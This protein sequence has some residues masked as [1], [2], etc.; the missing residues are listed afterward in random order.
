[1]RLVIWR[2][3]LLDENFL[4]SPATTRFSMPGKPT[5]RSRLSYDLRS[6][7]TLADK[8]ALGIFSRCSNHEANPLVLSVPPIKAYTSRWGMRIVKT[9]GT[10]CVQHQGKRS[11][12]LYRLKFLRLRLRDWVFLTVVSKTRSVNAPGWR[13]SEFK[14]VLSW[15]QAGWRPGRIGRLQWYPFIGIRRFTLHTNR[16]FRGSL[17]RCLISSWAT[18]LSVCNF[19]VLQ[20]PKV[21]HW[22]NKLFAQAEDMLQYA[23]R[24]NPCFLQ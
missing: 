8:I 14:A 16:I 23:E 15:F 19:I 11:G 5:W 21:Y 10:T 13:V 24:E 1:M 7:N 17:E 4:D 18:S 12:R 9:Q 20:E 22:T 3:I 2:R 6:H